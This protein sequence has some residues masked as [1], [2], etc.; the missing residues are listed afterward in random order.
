MDTSK[1]F[2]FYRPLY[3][4]PALR[5]TSDQTTILSPFIQRPWMANN[6]AAAASG[7]GS[8]GLKGIIAGGITGGIEICI[9]FPT[10]YV[11]TQLQLDEKG[12][13]IFYNKFSIFLSYILF[14]HDSLRHHV[15]IKHFFVLCNNLSNVLQVPVRDIMELRIVFKKL[16]KNAAFLDCTVV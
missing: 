12:K 1:M 15:L 14:P 11:K 2:S 10:E 7:G 5:S 16:L 4:S 6:G 8:K 13:E 9:T 3:E